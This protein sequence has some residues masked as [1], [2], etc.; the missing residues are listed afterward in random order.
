M[1]NL[2]H[3]KGHTMGGFG[4]VLKNQS[5]GVASTIGKVYIHSAGRTTDIEKF[6]D[7][8]D[9][10]L[11]FLEQAQACDL[12]DSRNKLITFLISCRQLHNR[13]S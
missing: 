3:F 4:G 9:D 6:W 2:A 11:G 7:Y 5:I 10:Q 12:K 8:T 13:P 1:I